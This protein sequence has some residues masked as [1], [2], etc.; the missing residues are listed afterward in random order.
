MWVSLFDR[1]VVE[2]G[3][4]GHIGRSSLVTRMTNLD[5]RV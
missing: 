2:V 3:D 5:R 1:R 4:A